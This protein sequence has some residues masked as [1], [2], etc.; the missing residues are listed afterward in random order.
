MTTQQQLA[1]HAQHVREAIAECDRRNLAGLDTTREVE[2][3]VRRV[4]ALRTFV[5]EHTGL[6][7]SAED[8]DLLDGA[9][10]GAMHFAPEPV[11]KEAA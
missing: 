4:E 10:L 3:V 7:L 9:T 1:R 2:I 11:Q 8:R 5:A 6:T